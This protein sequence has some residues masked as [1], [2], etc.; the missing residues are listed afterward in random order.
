MNK[1]QRQRQRRKFLE[2][3]CLSK[4]RHAT[5]AAALDHLRRHYMEK[6]DSSS[7]GQVR[8]YACRFCGGWHVGH[9]F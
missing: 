4:M 8:V 2:A 3:S 5:E 7:K 9:S 6:G 1:E